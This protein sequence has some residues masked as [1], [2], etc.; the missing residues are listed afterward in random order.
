MVAEPFI[1]LVHVK[2]LLPV[3]PEP[4]KGNRVLDARPAHVVHGLD[5]QSESL[6]YSASVEP[7]RRWPITRLNQP[8]ETRD[9]RGV[10][11]LG[12]DTFSGLG[13]VEPGATQLLRMAGR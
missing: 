3:R 9:P 13:R 11:A 5:R 6:R 4:V 8:A 12:G 1:Y 2:P 10:Q 7:R